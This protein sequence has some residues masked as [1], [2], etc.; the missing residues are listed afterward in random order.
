MVHEPVHLV[1]LQG[2]VR[3]VILPLQ[4]V[5]VLVLGLLFAH[6]KLFEF[7]RAASVLFDHEFVL[8]GRLHLVV[9]VDSAL[10][11]SLLLLVCQHDTVFILL[12]RIVFGQ[13]GQ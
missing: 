10:F 11:P 13:L 7:G 12:L 2:L 6:L 9:D 1:L 8:A 4:T 3:I 5:F